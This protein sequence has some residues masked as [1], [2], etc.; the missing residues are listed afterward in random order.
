MLHL[1]D[2]TYNNNNK[3]LI[4]IDT[5]KGVIHYFGCE[6]IELWRTTDSSKHIQKTDLHLNSN[7]YSRNGSVSWIILEGTEAPHLLSLLFLSLHDS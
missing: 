4:K 2:I 1:S 3:T 7:S 5:L 6:A